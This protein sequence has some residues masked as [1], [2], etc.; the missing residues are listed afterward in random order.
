MNNTNAVRQQQASKPKVATIPANYD[1]YSLI[2][3]GK[4]GKLSSKQHAKANGLGTLL[5]L[6]ADKD[7]THCIITDNLLKSTIYKKVPGTGA[8]ALAAML[9]KLKPVMSMVP[10]SNKVAAKLGA[11]V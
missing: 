7:T 3:Y 11:A 6:A 4:D 9:K 1:R 2:T 8:S 5:K 10:T